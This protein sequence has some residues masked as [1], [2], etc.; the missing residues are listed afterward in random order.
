MPS[1][2][3]NI[4]NNSAL[5]RLIR[6]EVKSRVK[7]T[8]RMMSEKEK[9]W[10]S[11]EETVLAYLPERDV[12]ALRRESREGG[13]PQ[14]TTI[15]IPY[16]Y[17][18]LM[19]A[20]TYFTSVFMGRSP[21]FQFSARH[22]EPAQA[23]QAI[24]ALHDYQTLC[25]QLLGPLYTWL[26]DVGKFGVGIVGNYW[27]DRFE[28]I[29][30]ITQI[31]EMDILGSPTGKMLKERTTQRA[32]TYSGNKLYNIQPWDFIFDV[33]FPIRD[34]QKG[35]Y[36]GVRRKLSWN[37]IK[38]RESQG[39]YMNLEFLNRSNSFDSQ[40]VDAG[41]DQLLRP[42]DSTAYMA[43]E[44][45]GLELEHPQEVEMYELCVELIPKEWKLG[46]SD[47]PEKWIFTVT[48]DY[49]VLMGAQPHGAY[50][51]KFPYQV[52]T[53]EPEGY[54][55]IPRGI[56]QTLE[57]IQQ[58][59]DWLVNSHFYNVR[60]ALNNKVL[61]DPS[62]VVMKD[63]LN[64]LPGGVIRLK[65]EAYGTDPQLAVR[66]LNVMDVTRTHL[67]DLQMMYGM[68][69]R[70]VG[71][72]DQIMGMLATGGRKTATEVRTSTSF[73]VNRLKTVSEYFSATAF[74]PLSQMLLQNTQQ[75]YDGEQKYKI[76]GDLTNTAGQQFMLVNPETIIGFYDFVPI[77]GS[78]PIDR[79]AQA[80]LWK[81]LMMQVRQMPDVALQYD[82][83]RMFEWVAQLAGMKNITQF[84]VQV[85]PDQALLQQAKLGNMVPLG[86]GRPSRSAGPSGGSPGGAANPK[87][88]P[89]MGPV[90]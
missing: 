90:L 71:V 59:I 8:Q 63:V 88:T 24:E 7:A 85:A 83:A 29:T 40:R 87:Q 74:D 61:V 45:T 57:P 22:G 89:G 72:N 78:L 55:L 14:Y 34:I 31:P 80:S 77:D 53:M 33:R 26:Y 42:E 84:K 65:P 27:E 39:Y 36:A 21:V 2:T 13:L 20:H 25:G 49:S 18:V 70:T 82:F 35:E 3:Q 50:H 4:P 69:E 44:P 64:P 19:S 30:Q 28:N 51:C 6:Q 56:P 76:A 75:Y 17:A 48:S 10:R 60:A 46:K 43:T 79:F 5:A 62:R 47:Y 58:T 23:V 38:R 81:E 68:G 67:A 54:G 16:T 66:Q 11:A 12:D 32:K 73:G 1:V 41:S 86:G 15:Q 9:V 52:I 37:E